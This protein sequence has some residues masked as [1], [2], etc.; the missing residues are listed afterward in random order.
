MT[1]NKPKLGYCLICKKAVKRKDRNKFCSSVCYHKSKIQTHLHC[2][3]CMKYKIRKDFYSYG[4]RVHSLCKKCHIQY[5]KNWHKKNKD[6]V[7]IYDRKQSD[8]VRIIVLKHY[9]NNKLKC[10]CCGEK[11]IEFLSIDHING[12]GNKER[13]SLK[14]YGGKV[15]YMWLIKNGFPKGLQVLCYNCNLSK[16]HCGGICPHKADDRKIID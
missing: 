16:Y 11:M 14:S 12:G 9:S 8:K 3:G 7:R 5:T 4:T 13:K 6:K 15:Y 2:F 10:I 1:I